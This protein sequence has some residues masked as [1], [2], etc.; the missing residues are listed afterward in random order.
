[1]PLEDRSALE[2]GA[3]CVEEAH[4]HLRPRPQAS[5]LLEDLDRAA[6]SVTVSVLSVQP[7]CPCLSDGAGCGFSCRFCRPMGLV[8]SWRWTASCRAAGGRGLPYHAPPFPLLPG[9]GS[10][11]NRGTLLM[12]FVCC[13]GTG[14]TLPF[15]LEKLRVGDCRFL[16]SF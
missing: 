1:M 11:Q 9:V 4:E 14:V 15:L 7:S 10:G 12:A 2:A 3:C 5:C 13:L 6:Q 16:V 8:S